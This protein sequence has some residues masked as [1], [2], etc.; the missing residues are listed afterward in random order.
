MY[1]FVFLLSGNTYYLFIYLLE[2]IWLDLA[3]AKN[4]RS[5]PLYRFAL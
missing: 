5:D 4:A 1:S 2:Q 3:R